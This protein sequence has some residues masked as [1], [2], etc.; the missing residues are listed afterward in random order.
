MTKPK[1]KSETEEYSDEQF[2]DMMA[3]M[4][5]KAKERAQAMNLAYI[6]SEREFEIIASIVVAV[7]TQTFRKDRE[8]ANRFM[9]HSIKIEEVATKVTDQIIETI[10]DKFEEFLLSRMQADDTSKN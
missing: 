10:R 1:Q 9:D 6:C 4:I 5:D 8:K 7:V 2:V 3:K